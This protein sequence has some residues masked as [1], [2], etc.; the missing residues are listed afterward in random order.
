MIDIRI[1]EGQAEYNFRLTTSKDAIKIENKDQ[2]ISFIYMPKKDQ[3]ELNIFH[4]KFDEFASV[5][6]NVKKSSLTFV[7]N[8]QMQLD[9]RTML[10]LE[11]KKISI[12]HVRK[13]IRLYKLVKYSINFD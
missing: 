2:L 7:I 9:D 5:L 10:K 12:L 13:F 1:G 4:F 8:D 11:E 3:L 6:D